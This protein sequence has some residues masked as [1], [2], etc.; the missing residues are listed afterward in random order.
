MPDLKLLF[1]DL[2]QLGLPKSQF[3]LINDEMS[4]NYN[5]DRYNFYVNLLDNVSD[6]DQKIASKVFGILARNRRQHERIQE[7]IDH[8][9]SAI[10]YLR[11]VYTKPDYV[12]GDK[13]DE[14][15]YGELYNLAKDVN[16]RILGMPVIGKKEEILVDFTGLKKEEI[17]KLE[18]EHE[19][20]VT[21]GL[22]PPYGYSSII[23]DLAQTS[24]AAAAPPSAAA[25]EAEA[26]AKAKAEA[27]GAAAAEEEEEINKLESEH[28]DEVTTGLQPPYGY[29]SIIPDLAQTSPA[30]A[31]PPSAAAAEAEAKAKAEA[32]A[33]GAAAAAEDLQ[34]TIEQIKNDKMIKP[35]HIT[36]KKIEGG[37]WVIDIDVPG[38][39]NCLFTSLEIA[40]LQDPLSRYGGGEL[41]GSGMR[42]KIIEKMKN[43]IN[44]DDDLKGDIRV[45]M[46]TDD[47]KND[48]I[49]NNKK[50]ETDKKNFN[51]NDDVDYYLNKYMN[52][53]KIFGGQLEI[54]Y[55][56][57]LLKRPI[58]VYKSIDNTT[59]NVQDYEKFLNEEYKD[60]LP[61]KIWFNN[62]NHYHALLTKDEGGLLLNIL[63]N[64]SDIIQGQPP[65]QP[66]AKASLSQ[67]K[68]SS[69]EKK[70]NE[71][72]TILKIIMN[73]IE[74]IAGHN[75]DTVKINKYVN[76]HNNEPEKV[77]I[78]DTNLANLK[79]YYGLSIYKAIKDGYIPINLENF[80]VIDGNTNRDMYIDSVKNIADYFID[81]INE[82]AKNVSHIT[83]DTAAP[84]LTSEIKENKYLNII[85][86][87]GAIKNIENK[88]TYLHG[89]LICLLIKIK[90]DPGLIKFF[91]NSNISEY[92]VSI[93][94][95]LFTENTDNSNNNILNIIEATKLNN[96]YDYR[97][98]FSD[99]NKDKLKNLKEYKTLKSLIATPLT[100]TGGAYTSNPQ[101]LDIIRQIGGSYFNERLNE[102]NKIREK[103]DISRKEREAAEDDV[104]IEYKNNPLYSPDMEKANYTDRIVF[105]AVTFMFRAISLVLVQ[106]AINTQFI[107]T[108]NKAFT[109]YFLIYSILFI[110]WILIVNMRKESH[111]VGLLFYYVNANYDSSIWLTRITVHLL[112]QLLVLPIPILLTPKFTSNTETD[113][114]EKRERLYNTLTFFTFVIWIITSLVAL[115]A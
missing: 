9:A 2:T 99:K 35:N 94:K 111:I 104:V 17:N 46:A 4:Y 31:A 32:E 6:P 3:S 101:M 91:N 82:Q 51:G 102:L 60:K 15:N 71:Y 58:H 42:N 44:T 45:L 8:I 53:D 10:T 14:R 66:P 67:L 22:Q 28:E 89:I 7:K 49:K 65:Q 76:G 92:I 43:E 80:A 97:Y 27:A 79:T 112:L 62:N 109:Y 70:Q 106:S 38:D 81:K 105:I 107:T 84:L 20:E 57:K 12:G 36:A 18:S 55:A 90:G 86:N 24:P 72:E 11:S 40:S 21:T 88:I 5:P 13:K 78:G 16:D 115:R 114:F 34:Q 75:G 39:G 54:I 37:D 77:L 47:I 87:P 113:S 61:V 52:N 19:D 50:Y 103:P 33:A 98:L 85:W 1:Q 83:R 108:F 48:L 96:T 25:A 110:I 74:F 59:I 64:K 68:V 100:N 95:L 93:N 56:A 29:S 26:K 30:A 73:L 63:N 69:N 23:P 41:N